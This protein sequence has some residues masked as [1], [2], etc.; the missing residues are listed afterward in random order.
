MNLLVYSV[1]LLCFLTPGIFAAFKPTG[2]Y[3]LSMGEIVPLCKMVKKFSETGTPPDPEPFD[4]SAGSDPATCIYFAWT[5]CEKPSSNPNKPCEPSSNPNKPCGWYEMKK[6]GADQRK[7]RSFFEY[8]ER[9]KRNLAL[10]KPDGPVILG[11]PDDHDDFP[12][13]S[14]KVL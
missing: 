3:D 11:F 1:A 10:G 7:K 2:Q 13:E 6:C 4:E 14:I 5:S 9:I 12:G 8:I